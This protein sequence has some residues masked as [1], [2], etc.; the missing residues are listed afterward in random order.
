[1]FLAADGRRLDRHRAGRVVR[2]VARRAGIGKT[3][4]PHTLG[5]A[6]I[7]AALDAGVPL[8]DVQEAASHA[9]P[10][11]T[12]RYGLRQPGPACHLYRRRLHRGRR[13]VT[14]TGRRK[15]RL[16][17]TAV[18]RTARD[19][20]APAAVPVADTDLVVAGPVDSEVLPER[21]PLQDVPVEIFLPDRQVQP[22][23]SLPCAVRSPCRSPSTF[24]RRTIRRQVTGLFQD[25]GADLIT[26]PCDVLGL[27]TL[28]DTS[29]ASRGLPSFAGRRGGA[30]P[31]P[32]QPWPGRRLAGY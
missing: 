31:G 21:A 16:A 32:A 2:K 4:T 15:L 11:T 9:D 6:F 29:I 30:G 25:A 3:V 27:P 23:Y 18:R 19:G 1:V 24:S 20:P 22:R 13:P 8:R 14:R 17:A 5:H 10:R 26:A 28:T 7:T 12:M